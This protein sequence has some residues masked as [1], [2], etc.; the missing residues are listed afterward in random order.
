MNSSI[1]ALPEKQREYAVENTD[2]IDIS[3]KQSVRII[4]EETQSAWS[5]KNQKEQEKVTKQLMDIY[6]QYYSTN[7]AADRIRKRTFKDIVIAKIR[8]FRA[9]AKSALSNYRVKIR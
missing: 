3:S 6:D 7:T 1:S 2:L 5:R 8:Q 9:T 4:P